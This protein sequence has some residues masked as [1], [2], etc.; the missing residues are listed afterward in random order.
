MASSSEIDSVYFGFTDLHGF[1]DFV[2][3]V[4]SCAPDLFPQEDWLPTDQQMN[5]ERAFVA[6]RYGL[7]ITMKKGEESP[8]LERCR[9]LVEQAYAEYQA[10]RDLAGQTKLEEVH[11]LLRKLPSK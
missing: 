9:E 8:L 5:L 10:G 11:Q 3:L 2:V 7:A 6:L 1:K 4:L